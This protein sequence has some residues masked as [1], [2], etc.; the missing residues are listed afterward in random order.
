[1]KGSPIMSNNPNI[2]EMRLPVS[3]LTDREIAEET[4]TLLRGFADALEAISSNPMM[5]AMVPGLPR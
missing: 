5:R 1:M 3:D 4:L 2:L